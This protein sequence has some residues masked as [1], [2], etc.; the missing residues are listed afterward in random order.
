MTV[1]GIQPARLWMGNILPPALDAYYR[2]STLVGNYGLVYCRESC[3]L[4]MEH[5]VKNLMHG[6]QELSSRSLNMVIGEHCYTALTK[7]TVYI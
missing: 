1:G 3:F 6:F 4:C 5:D 2:A 7:C